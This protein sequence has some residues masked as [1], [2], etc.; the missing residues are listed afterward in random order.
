MSGKL[1]DT[2]IVIALFA[3]DPSVT[4]NL[5]RAEEVFIPSIVLGD[6]YFGAQNSSRLQ[7]NL[8]QIDAFAES[9]TALHCDKF[10]A[11]YYGQIKRKLKIKG[12]PIPEND[13]WIS[14]IAL[15]FGLVLISRDQH[16]VAVEEMILE[17][18]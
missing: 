16:F 15:Q 3:K 7:E 2:N 13:I 12:T 11:K 17:R 18:W 1:L 10:T 8:A 14:A 9:S 4:D 6:L 5:A